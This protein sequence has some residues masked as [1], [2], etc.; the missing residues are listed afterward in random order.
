MTWTKKLDSPFPFYLNDDRKNVLFILGKAVFVFFFLILFKTSNP[1]HLE[2]TT[3]QKGIFATATFLCLLLTIVILPR[4]FPQLF[5]TDQ[6]TVRK[7]ILHTILNVVVI[8]IVCTAIDEL[9]V[10]PQR[11]LWANTVGAVQQVVII[12]SIPV[13]LMTLILRNNMLQQNLRA[14][15]QA[16]QELERIREIK[17]VKTEPRKHVHSL[18]LKSETTETLSLQLA[19]LLFIEADDNYSTVYWKNGEGVQKKLLRANLKNLE[20]QINNVY[21][22]RCHRS[23]IVNIA[24]I[25]RVSGNSNGYKLQ[26]RDTEFS[27]PVSRQKGRDI[28]QKIQQ[29][30]NILEMA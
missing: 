16:N 18:T 23:F 26:I 10:C 13:S 4:L 27:I 30:S 21:A 25:D 12:G 28:M 29:M 15:I 17:D 6:W 7:Y 3:F 8:G 14:A 2:L 19:D 9:Y 5:D 24:A 1:N 22:I 11:S 20:T